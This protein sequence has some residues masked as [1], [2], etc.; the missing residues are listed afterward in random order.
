M[1]RGPG[2]LGSESS[3]RRRCCAAATRAA[4]PRTSPVRAGSR[5]GSE[6]RAG[7]WL[8]SLAGMDLTLSACFVQV[9]DPD[10]ALAFYRDAL[11]LELRNDVAREAFRG[12][13][14]AAN[15]VELASSGR[16]RCCAAATRAASPRTSP[17]RAGSRA[18]SEKRAGRWLPSLAGMDLTL[19]ACFVQVHDPDLALAFYRDALGLELRND[20]A[21]EA[22]RGHWRAAN[23]VEL[24]KEPQSAT[25]ARNSVVR[26]RLSLAVSLSSLED[27]NGIRQHPGAVA[28]A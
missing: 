23:T 27:A 8:P 26:P 15:T 25:C 24:A 22:F 9:H 11:G 5:A 13:W 1:R 7:R 18:G 12:H 14:R 3:G 20:V 17:V 2:Q 6:K 21:R 10:L 4:S 16:R 19:S 28:A